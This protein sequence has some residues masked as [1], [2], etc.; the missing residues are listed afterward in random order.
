MLA[1][2]RLDGLVCDTHFRCSLWWKRDVSMDLLQL[3]RGTYTTELL[4]AVGALQVLGGRLS[5]RGSWCDWPKGNGAQRGGAN[6][7]A[8]PTRLLRQWRRPHNC[9]PPSELSTV[10]RERV[11]AGRRRAAMRCV[12]AP[13]LARCWWRW[14][15]GLPHRRRARARARATHHGCPACRTFGQARLR[16]RRGRKGRGREGQNDML[17]PSAALGMPL[18]TA[19]RWGAFL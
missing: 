19:G 1:I 11:R 8:T 7:E 5:H 6:T 15:T 4:A 9:L 18:S 13:P 2:L 16:R 3:S 17:Y 10:A 12:G 14:C